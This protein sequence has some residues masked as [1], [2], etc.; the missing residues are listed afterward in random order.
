[1]VL[2]YFLLANSDFAKLPGKITGKE[3]VS[4]FFGNAKYFQSL[5]MTNA[6]LKTLPFLTISV[7]SSPFR[8]QGPWFSYKPYR[9]TFFEIR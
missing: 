3:K 6:S 2:S 7:L 4:I 5:K 9:P 1:M 8:G